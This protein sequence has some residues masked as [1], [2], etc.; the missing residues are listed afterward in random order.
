MNNRILV[1]TVTRDVE[2][3][4][5]PRGIYQARFRQAKPIHCTRARA[6]LLVLATAPAT[7]RTY[8]RLYNDQ[9]LRVHETVDLQ[10][11]W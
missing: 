1:S 11:G 5:S 3:V 7:E 4:C 6:I 9:L 2:A 8:T 10:T